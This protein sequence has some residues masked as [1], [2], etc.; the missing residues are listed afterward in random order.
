[1]TKPASQFVY[2]TYIRAEQAAVWRALTSPEFT[3]QYWFGMTID[4]DWKLGGPWKLLFEDG[5]IADQGEVLEIDEPNRLVIS[6]RNQFKP[7]YEVEGFTR[8]AFDLEKDGEAVKLT[9][10]HEID[11]ADSKVIHAVSGGWPKVLSNLKS[12]LEIGAIAV[13]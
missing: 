12:L 6:W 7:E 1:M 5:R 3:R 9:V 8:C 10:T 2:V 13:A 11:L 4:G